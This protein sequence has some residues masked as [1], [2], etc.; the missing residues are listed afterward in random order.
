MKLIPWIAG[1]LICTLAAGCFGKEARTK[2]IEE[3]KATVA[4]LEQEVADLEASGADP[5]ILAKTKA[6]L[7]VARDVLKAAEEANESQF[8]NAV[9]TILG[10]MLSIGLGL[11]GR[12]T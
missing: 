8:G 12:R 3:S 1:L 5:E 9:G 6:A 2:T 11:A 10:L 7:A 4:S